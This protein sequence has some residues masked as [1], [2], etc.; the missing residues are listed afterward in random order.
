MFLAKNLR[1]SNEYIK[2]MQE[3]REN[4]LFKDLKAWEK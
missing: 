2:F 3:Q 4:F 1:G